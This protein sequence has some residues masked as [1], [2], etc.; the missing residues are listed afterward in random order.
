MYATALLFFIYILK[1]S[2]SDAMHFYSPI[3]FE[4]M[5]EKGGEIT[6]VIRH[7]GAVSPPIAP[8]THPFARRY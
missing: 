5:K 3:F 6:D 8:A 4:L 2:P 1:T 7:P